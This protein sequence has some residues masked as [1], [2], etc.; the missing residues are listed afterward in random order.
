MIGSSL[1]IFAMS[2]ALRI[3]RVGPASKATGKRPASAGCMASSAGSSTG[4]GVRASFFCIGQRAARHPEVV[5]A[6]RAAGHGVENHTFH[7]HHGF[8]FSGPRALGAERAGPARFTGGAELPAADT[9]G[10][11]VA[12]AA[13]EDTGDA[14]AGSAAASDLPAVAKRPVKRVKRAGRPR[15]G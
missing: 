10:G 14:D 7:H 1:N 8:A 3:S 15:R 5:A 11:F 2:S 6:V 12:S 13:Y 9:R 4:R